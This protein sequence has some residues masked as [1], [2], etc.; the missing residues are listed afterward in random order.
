MQ[1][2]SMDTHLLDICGGTET[3]SF[4]FL[5]YSLAFVAIEVVIDNN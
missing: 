3:G 1:G 2:L 4:T 5:D